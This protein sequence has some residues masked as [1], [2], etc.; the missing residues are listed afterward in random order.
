MP[1]RYAKNR[2]TLPAGYQFGD[3][4]LTDEDIYIRTLIAAARQ[5]CEADARDVHLEFTGPWTTFLLP[6]NPSDEAV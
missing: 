1:Y 5:W 4:A 6:R 2:S 3:A